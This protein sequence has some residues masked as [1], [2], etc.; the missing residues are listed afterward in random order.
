MEN[1]DHFL[2]R[3][4]AGSLYGG[5]VD[6]VLSC[7]DNFQARMSINQAR[8]MAPTPPQCGFAGRARALAAETSDA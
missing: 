4:A 8:A 5:P 2:G 6:L 1:F 3:I 7:V